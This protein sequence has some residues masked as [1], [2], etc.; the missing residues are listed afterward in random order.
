MKLQSIGKP[1]F[2]ALAVALL[3]CFFAPAIARADNVPPD[4]LYGKVDLSNLGKV[5]VQSSQTM[6]TLDTFARQVIWQITG[7]ETLDGH[8]SLYTLMDMAFRPDKYV[9]RNIIKIK[10]VPLR[11]E[12][13]LL[14]GITNDEKE[15][16]VHDGTI[17][18]T[19]IEKPEVG[20]LFRSA[21]AK[22]VAKSDAIN[23]LMDAAVAM[24]AVCQSPG[25][26]IPVA[27]ILPSPN[28][29]DQTN[30]HRLD[31]FQGNVPAIG[32]AMFETLT[33]EGR[34]LQPPLPGYD[35]QLPKLNAIYDR[36]TA[37]GDAWAANDPAKVKMEADGLADLLPTINPA[38]Y[39][40][41]AKRATEVMYNHLTRLTIPGASFY[42]LALVLFL[43]ASQSGVIGLRLW[44]IRLMIIG[45]I[46]HTAGIAI[47]WWLIGGIFP[48]IKNEFESVMFSAWF[49]VLVGLLLELRRSRGIIGAA[50]SFVGMMSL[51]AIFAAPYITGREIGGEIG[52][53]QGVLMSYWLYIH[54]TM[55][56][57]SYALIGMGFMLSLWWLARYYTDYGTLRRVPA[58][59]LSS[60]AA[61]RGFPIE[62]APAKSKS[63][64]TSAKGSANP[65]GSAGGM[66]GNLGGSGAIGSGAM[67]SGALAGG[68]GSSA[69]APGAV[70]MF[71]FAQ[72]LSMLFFVERVPEQVASA[73]KAEARAV[74]ES[75]TRGF[76]ATLDLCNLVVLQLAFWVLGCGIV[77]G[78]IWADQS[79]GRPWGWDPKETFALVTWIVYLIVVHTRVVTMNKAWWTAVLSCIGFFIMLFNWI[80]VNFMLVGL[81]SY[82]WIS[83]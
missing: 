3:A 31:Q 18:L 62:A 38:V 67:G 41:N 1:C 21:Q 52:Q 4:P 6:K 23:D 29:P 63:R 28:A 82:A 69:L 59:L 39:P 27:I 22:S 50:S 10:N 70:A 51:V 17:S 44:A 60:D 43:M 40:S 9:D 74:A 32:S 54:V 58:N 78:A 24:H 53:V 34:P 2:F 19:F 14:N 7:H 42:F 30:W 77:C 8:D 56:T 66:P 36:Y 61:P 13:R 16:I 80:G 73:S 81:H 48:P 11:E 55:V 57:A 72:T 64:E 35:Q 71:T 12:F 25:R 65:G 33:A 75:Q 47:R 46:I 5:A 20:D 68:L 37:L 79:W 49:G 83:F 15:R 45:F 76:L 26:L